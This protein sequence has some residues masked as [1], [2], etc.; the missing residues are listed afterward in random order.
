[1]THHVMTLYSAKEEIKNKVRTIKDFK[2][3]ET[4]DGFEFLITGTGFLYNM[5]RVITAYVLEC[6]RGIRKPD[7]LNMI[8]K[9]DRTMIPKTAPGEGLYQ[10]K[11]WYE[12][13]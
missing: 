7:T 2:V 12:K 13:L 3:I 1:I 10:E 4:A 11:V 8:A 9:K 6:G 5:V